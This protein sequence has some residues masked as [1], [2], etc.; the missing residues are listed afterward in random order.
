MQIPLGRPS[1]S[2]FGADSADWRG[3]CGDAY[4]WMTGLWWNERT[5]TTLVYVI[6]GMPETNRRQA[7]HSALTAAEQGVIDRALAEVA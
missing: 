3:H 5:Q 4:G 6:N 1:D 7:A 2:S